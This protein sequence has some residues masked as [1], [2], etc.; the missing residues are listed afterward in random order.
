MTDMLRSIRRG[1]QSPERV[2]LLV[3]GYGDQPEPFL[4]RVARLDLHES[5][6]VVAVEPFLAGPTG[7]RWYEVDEHGPDPT[8]LTDAVHALDATCSAVLMDAGLTGDALAVA[9]FSQGGALALAHLLDPTASCRPGAVAGLAAY[10]PTRDDGCIDRSR[11][12]DRP[13]L[14][15]HGRDDAVV[16]PLRGRSAARALHRSGALVTWSEVDGG[17]R[18]DTPLTN[19]L[20]IWL[21]QLTS[22]ERPHTPP[23]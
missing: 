19:P 16:E 6:A 3:P 5:W 22:G 9:G 1:P 12:H 23:I 13:I 7:P 11:A 17:H 18:F 8:A 15:V 21:G 10:L 14:L 20:R 4:D 2:L